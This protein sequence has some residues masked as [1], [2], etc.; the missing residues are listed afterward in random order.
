MSGGMMFSACSCI[1]GL[2]G[3]ACND[4]TQAEPDHQL[5]I[6]T[7]LLTTTNL[8]MLS[9][10]MLAAYR[11]HYAESVVYA[12]HIIFS[13]LDHACA[14]QIYSICVLN[15]SILGFSDILVRAECVRCPWLL[16]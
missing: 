5:L 15:V 3:P 9:A 13:S 8:A 14:G 1:A 2:T 10:L 12:S 7:L 6:A 16:A 4:P 11:A